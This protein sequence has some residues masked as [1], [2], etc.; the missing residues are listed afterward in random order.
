M[1]S[2]RVAREGRLIGLSVPLIRFSSRNARIKH[3]DWNRGEAQ[4]DREP[5][6]VGEF[7]EPA[8]VSREGDCRKAVW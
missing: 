8:L 7:G 4:Y 3:E 6:I 5:R 1:E 2:A